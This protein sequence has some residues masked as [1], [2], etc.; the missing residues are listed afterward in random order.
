MAS[1]S[2]RSSTSIQIQTN[3]DN[4]NRGFKNLADT[5]G[6]SFQCMREFGES[7]VR[8]SR[9]LNEASEI[10]SKPYQCD[11]AI[12]NVRKCCRTA[13]NMLDK[14]DD[15]TH[16]CQSSMMTN[17]IDGC[18]EW[19][20]DFEP[21]EKLIEKIETSSNEAQKFY[22]E[23]RSD[24]ERAGR[25]C[26]T[27][28]GACRRKAEEEK[29]KKNVTKAVGGTAAAGAI[30]TGVGAGVATSIIAG[31]FT[32]GIGTVVGLGLTAAGATVAGAATGTAIAAGTHAL[33]SE[34]EKA[35]DKF[36]AAA[37]SFNSLSTD[38]TKLFEFATRYYKNISNLK[39]ILIDITIDCDSLSYTQTEEIEQAVVVVQSKCGAIQTQS[40]EICTKVKRAIQN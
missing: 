36:N 7:I 20:P 21:L 38:S 15:I 2:Y 5:V 27:A 16:Y 8:T 28:A 25:S 13:Y 3:V 29:T 40:T 4:I 26:T 12:E 1:Y 14:M 18:N 37:S 33:A 19:P 31:V 22:R 23:L 17:A 6:P 32:F 39:K 35:G 11:T 10:E 34:Y 9:N 30:A 24:C